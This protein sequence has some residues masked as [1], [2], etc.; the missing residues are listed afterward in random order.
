MASSEITQALHE[1]DRF[2]AI[3]TSG[4]VYPAA[5]FV[6]VARLAGAHTVELS[7]EPSV[8]ASRFHERMYGPATEIVTEYV[9]SFLG[10]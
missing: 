5:A 4:N 6:E 10:S 1:C 9:E 2:I 7:L 8:G 3:G